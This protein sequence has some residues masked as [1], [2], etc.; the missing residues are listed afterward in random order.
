MKTADYNAVA[1]AAIALGVPVRWLLELLWFETNRTLDPLARN[2]ISGARGLIQF[3]NTTARGLG[4]A[5]ADDLVAKRPTVVAQMPLVVSYLRRYRPFPTKQ[6]LFMSV[7]YPTS[8]YVPED[9]LFSASVQRDNPGIRTVADY[10]RKADSLARTL[11]V[12]GAGAALVLVVAVAL[13]VFLRR[14]G[15]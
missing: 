5:G 11:P 14:P 2:A 10:M 1:D 8:R 15:A 7:F 12:I 4:F 13:V 3:T 6:A 9:T